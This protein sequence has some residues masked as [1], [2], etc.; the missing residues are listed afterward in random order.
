V[1]GDPIVSVVK[2]VSP[3]VV[4]VTTAVPNPNALV[5]G[6]AIG[7]GVGTGFVVRSD[8]IIV[9]NFHVVEGALNI[10]ISLPPPEHRSW[11]A[12]VIGAD[13]ERDLAVLKVNATKLITIPLGDGKDVQLGERV[14]ALGYALAL[15]GGPTVTSGIISALARTVQA[16]DPQAQGGTR[17]YQDALQT[18]AAINPGNSGGPLVDVAGNVVGIN[19]AGNQQAENVGF[20]IA[21][22]DSVKSLIAQAI[23]HP[24][25][26]M[27]FLGVSSQ[28]VDAGV[29]AQFDLAVDHGAL[30]LAVAPGGPAD[31]GGI[32]QGDVIIAFGGQPVRS[33]DDLGK[34]ILQRRPGAV[35]AVGLVRSTGNRVTVTVTLSVRPLPTG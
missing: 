35:V 16:S 23:A 4:N 19:T 7:K 24:Q 25:G 31:K 6:S 28:T 26:A 8:G 27:A 22:T 3:A 32:R 11:T 10:R 33:S 21:I 34:L 2:K 13:Q 12:R 5:G 9:T 1:A 18:D 30:V 14:V 15:P 20:A 29:A 17:T